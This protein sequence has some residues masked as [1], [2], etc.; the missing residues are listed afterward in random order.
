MK[1]CKILSLL[2]AFLLST[3]VVGAG[4]DV[5][6]QRVPGNG[7]QARVTTGPKGKVHLVYYKGRPEAGNLYYVSAK[8][9]T[10]KFSKPIQVNSQS[11][12]AISMGTIRGA[13]VALGRRGRLHVAWNG[14]KKAKPQAAGG[15]TPMLYTRLNDSGAAFEKQRNLI[16]SK[17]GL[18]GGGAVAADSKGNVYV[19]WHAFGKGVKNEQNRRL[20][21][22]RSKDDGKTF[23][24][25][26]PAIKQNTG[27]CA[28]CGLG[29]TV[30]A[31]G[32]VFVLYRAATQSTERGMVLLVS[33]NQA[34]SFKGQAINRWK[35]NSCIMSSANLTRNSNGVLATWE[36]KQQ[37]FVAPIDSKSQKLGKAI[38]AP[39]RGPK[40][41][42]A[43]AVA[44]K[45]GE[46]LLVW[47]EGTGWN[48][49]GAIVW[50]VFNAQG[51]P[52]KA[53]SGKKQGLAAWSFPAAYVRKDGGFTILF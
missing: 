31:D 11:G 44:N 38:A 35:L 29:S 15:Q 16:N 41:K 30:D 3:I 47:T 6:V 14:S 17:T 46:I 13:Q 10:S 53:A 51:K 24:K 40:R 52:I 27:C 1:L 37:V 4:P 8:N 45:N 9:G 48:K 33:K 19:M 21:V 26:R 25:E 32:R 28:C 42:H 20:F 23:S 12:S 50:Q 18:D 39:G 34:K 49:G 7:I 5:D 43:F 22:V 2:G 36:H